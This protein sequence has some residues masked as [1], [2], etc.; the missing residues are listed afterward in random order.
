MEQDYN[1]HDEDALSRSLVAGQSAWN[2]IITGM[3]KMRLHE[4]RSLTKVRNRTMTSRTKSNGQHWRRTDGAP[5]WSPSYRNNRLGQSYVSWKRPATT[6]RDRSHTAA[7][8]GRVSAYRYGPTQ[9]AGPF[10]PGRPH[11]PNSTLP[12]VLV[13]RLDPT[14]RSGSVR[15][16]PGSEHRRTA[17]C[18]FSPGRMFLACRNISC[19]IVSRLTA[20]TNC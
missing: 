5:D 10:L 14:P 11:G 18:L 4:A 6:S 1:G 8:D 15:S 13:G 20:P 19:V 17:D 2:K 3:T 9:P 7:T 16:G 12:G